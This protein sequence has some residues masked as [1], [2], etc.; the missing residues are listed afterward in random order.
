MIDPKNLPD[1]VEVLKAMILSSHAEIAGKDTEIANRN[2]EIA[3]KD[4]LIERK[5]DRK[6]CAVHTVAL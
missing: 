4:A 2:A 3:G 5:E 1:D 6:R